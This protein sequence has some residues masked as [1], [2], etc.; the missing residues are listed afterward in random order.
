MGLRCPSCVKQMTAGIQGVG[1]GNCGNMM[2][3][4][5]LPGEA[6]GDVGIDGPG[7][8]CGE[9]QDCYC[10]S[11]KVLL[12]NPFWNLNNINAGNFGVLSLGICR[13]LRGIN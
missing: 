8:Q 6:V 7:P 11:A 1:R 12:W 13:R 2:S 5:L 3:L 4:Q 9:S 10:S